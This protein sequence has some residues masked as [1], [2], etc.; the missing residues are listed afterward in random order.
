MPKIDAHVHMWNIPEAHQE[1]LVRL[2]V[3]HNFRWLDLCAGGVEWPRL[4]AQMTLARG[5]KDRH[6]DKVEWAAS[7]NL[8]NWGQADWQR[9]AL[10]TIAAS[11]S[12]GAVAI[13]S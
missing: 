10:Q 11:F 1:A 12:E 6:R 2:A 8:S 9:S 7:F 4:Q 13:K 3:R 5:L